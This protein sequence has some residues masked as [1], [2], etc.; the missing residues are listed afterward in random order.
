LDENSK[1]AAKKVERLHT[2]L[3][4]WLISFILQILKH[5]KDNAYSDGKEQCT[6]FD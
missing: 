5:P 2:P 1:I 6:H 3:H 4:P